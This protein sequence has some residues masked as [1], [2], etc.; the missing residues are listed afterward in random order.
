MRLDL[1]Q[2]GIQL[3]KNPI[4]KLASGTFERTKVSEIRKAVSREEARAELREALACALH[5]P[6]APRSQK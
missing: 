4:V 2:V 6:T 1:E 5:A 3:R